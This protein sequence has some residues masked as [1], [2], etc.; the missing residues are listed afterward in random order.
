MRKRKKP[1][2]LSERED[3]LDKEL[4]FA[5]GAVGA[6]GSCLLEQCDFECESNNVQ[7]IRV[8]SK[9]HTTNTGHITQVECV[10]L[11]EIK[12]KIKARDNGVG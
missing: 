8:A 9:I 4:E 1:T 5:T 3:Q 12:P 7:D 6:I 10:Y 11:L 2:S